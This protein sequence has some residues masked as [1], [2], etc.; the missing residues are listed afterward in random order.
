MNINLELNE[1]DALHLINW[2]FDNAMG[3]DEG[4]YH[5][6]VFDHLMA[7]V[8]KQFEFVLEPACRPAFRSREKR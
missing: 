2:L 8:V 5:I 1:K 4:Y 7:A 3:N 6:S